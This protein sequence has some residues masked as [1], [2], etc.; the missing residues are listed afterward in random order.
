M[1]VGAVDQVRDPERQGDLLD[2]PGPRRRRL[3]A[4][5]ERQLEL[6]ADGC[7][8]DLGLGVLADE[9]DQAAELGRAVVAHIEARRP[10]APR[11]L[12]AVVVGHE[13]AAAAQQRRL[14]AARAPGED[15]QLAVGDLEVDVRAAPAWRRPGTST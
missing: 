14:A 13:P 4:Q 12:A 6:A 5:L 2:R 11:D 1:S 3:A 9:A 8:D 7:R 10:R 15:H